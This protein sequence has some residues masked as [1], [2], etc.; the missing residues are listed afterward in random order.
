MRV[1]HQPGNT[2]VQ[3]TGVSRTQSGEKAQAKEQAGRA[4]A[5]TAATT[6]PGS[7]KTEISG[8]AKEFAQAK[9]VASQAPDV[10]EDKI[11][12]LKARIAAGTYQIDANKIAD[13]MVDDH[14]ALSAAGIG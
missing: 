10:R 14:Q 3:G 9:A 1:N 2:Q 13:K 5:S 4:G 7:V 11:A 8:K 12:A 6:I